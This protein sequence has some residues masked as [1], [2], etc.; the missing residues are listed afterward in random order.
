M[1]DIQFESEDTVTPEEKRATLLKLYEEGL[2]HDENGK[3]SIENK[4]RILEAFGF[5]GYENARDISSL[6]LAK[7]S[8]ENLALREG[9]VEPDVY[10]EHSLHITE[11]T[12]FLLSTEFKR[13]RVKEGLKA[14]FL[15]HIEEHEKM[16]KE[17][18]KKKK[19][20]EK[21]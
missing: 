16:E 1:H 13:S 18:K 12:R 15:K 4:N 9:E 11:H 19:E 6:H 3:L 20:E 8:E 5:G 10:D 21:V 2:L 17:K 14:R 7:A